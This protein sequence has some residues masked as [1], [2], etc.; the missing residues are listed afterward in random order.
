[1]LCDN[2]KAC[3]VCARLLSTEDVRCTDVNADAPR[4]HHTLAIKYRSLN[5]ARK[6]SRHNNRERWRV[7]WKREEGE[8]EWKM[9]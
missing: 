3:V 7:G 2:C 8:D 1:L 5:I 6:K 4:A 9:R